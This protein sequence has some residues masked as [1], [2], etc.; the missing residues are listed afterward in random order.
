MPPTGEPDGVP[1]ARDPQPTRQGH[2]IVLGG[3]NPALRDR[4]L[5][6]EPLRAGSAVP[7][8]IE[9]RMIGQD[10]DSGADDEHHEEHV[11]EVLQLQPPRK[12][13]IDRGRGLRDTWVLVDEGLDAWKLPQTLCEGDQE[14]ERRRADR[15]RPQDAD[16]APAYADS[17]NYAL[18]WR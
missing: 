17:G 3:P 9:P 14:N 13:G 1:N 11:Q 16:P 7:M 12:T 18:L 8:P 10:L 15:Y 5:E 6:A 4:V 2:R